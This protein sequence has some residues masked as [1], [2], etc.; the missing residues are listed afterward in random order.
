MYSYDCTCFNI[1][2]LCLLIWYRFC[3]NFLVGGPADK[4][5]LKTQEVVIAVNA[6]DTTE[7]SHQ[8]VVSIISN[9]KTPGVWLTVCEGP[10]DSTGRGQPSIPALPQSINNRLGFNRVHSLGSISMSTPMIPRNMTD[11]SFRYSND[12]S[13]PKYQELPKYSPRGS[14]GG[15]G[16]GG[17]LVSKPVTCSMATMGTGISPLTRKV[18]I[19]NAQQDGHSSSSSATQYH[20]QYHPQQ[21]QQQQQQLHHQ[22]LQQ[23][24]SLP[25]QNG[26]FSSYGVSH[27]SLL[28]TGSKSSPTPSATNFTS[29]SVLVL[30]IGP[31]EIPDAWSTRELSSKCLQECTRN[32][33]SQRQEFVEAFLE[34]T[35][36]SMKILAVSQTLIFKHKREELYYAGVCSNDEQYFGIVTRKLEHKSTKKSLSGSSIAKPMRAHMCHVFKVIQHKSVLILHSGDPKDS[37]SGKS[38]KQQQQQ[39]LQPKQKTIPIFSCVTVV[40]A[41]QGLFTNPSPGSKILDEMTG[42][43]PSASSAES[44]FSNG[45]QD[46]AKKKKLDVVDLRPSAYLAPPSSSSSSIS[47]GLIGSGLNSVIHSNP[48]MYVS[49]QHGSSSN[50]AGSSLVSHSR[51]LSNP[52]HTSPGLGMPPP[53]YPISIGTPVYHQRA[54]MLGGSGGTGGGGTSW[55]ASDSP[56]EENHSRSGSWDGKMSTQ[57]GGGGVGMPSSGGAYERGGNNG[58]YHHDISSGV[59]GGYSAGPKRSGNNSLKR[60]SNHSPLQYDRMKPISD[61]SSMSSLSDSRASSPTRVSH[62]SSFTSHSRSPSPNRSLSYSSRSRTPSPVS[63]RAHAPPKPPPSHKSSRVVGGVS[64]TTRRARMEVA[65]TIRAAA[66]M[67]QASRLSAHPRTPL[68]RQVRLLRNYELFF[69]SEIVCESWLVLKSAY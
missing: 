52:A 46:K 55:Y 6:Q 7:L 34:V 23:R 28:S 69:L 9:T 32:L 47:T 40:N 1:M 26:H 12:D 31:V 58:G 25:I 43:K 2:L 44:M 20:H 21:Q 29:A 64:S 15:V 22:H 11:S 61:D 49:L 19:Q 65:S 8:E 41:I 36:T 39:H 57:G 17:G 60:N 13:L 33:L 48:N 38:N 56:K 62:R 30:Y 45:N 59:G 24:P 10:E 51:S 50:K 54:G 27:P 35:L 18:L 16:G 3:D 67:S 66:A 5:G 14:G 63:T 53:D 68:K 42:I 4:A 37:K